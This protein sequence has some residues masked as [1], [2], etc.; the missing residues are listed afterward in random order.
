MS[1]KLHIIIALFF[2]VVSS[3]SFAAQPKEEL[4][5]IKKELKIHKKKLE[6]TKKIEE[7]VLEDLKRVS[8]QLSE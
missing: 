6:E 1:K 2:I 3:V 5:Q 8:R 4:K 7:N